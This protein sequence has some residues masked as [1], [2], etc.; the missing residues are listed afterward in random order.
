MAQSKSPT[1]RGRID[2]A[3][4]TDEVKDTKVNRHRTDEDDCHQ[5][6]KPDMIQIDRAMTF[7]D[8]MSDESSILSD[9]TPSEEGIRIGS[10]EQELAVSRLVRHRG[11]LENQIHIQMADHGGFPDARNRDDLP[12]SSDEIS[13][14][15]LSKGEIRGNRARSVLH[16]IYFER[17]GMSLQGYYTGTTRDQQPHGSGVLRFQNGDF[18]CGQFERGVFQGQGSLLLRREGTLQ[19]YRGHF[20]RNEFIAPNA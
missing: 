12:L 17:S 20:S 15:E 14:P 11:L 9:V 1:T 8:D 5:G 2:G 16:E 4:R 3:G 10:L 13:F 7:S 6:L 19:K 18:Y